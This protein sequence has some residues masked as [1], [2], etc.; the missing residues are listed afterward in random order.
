MGAAACSCEL[1]SGG[2]QPVEEIIDAS[3]AV[4][5]MQTEPKNLIIELK[6]RSCT[7][8]FLN[9]PEASGGESRDRAFTEPWNDSSKSKASVLPT[10]LFRTAQLTFS[11]IRKLRQA[12]GPKTCSEEDEAHPDFSGDWL[13][14]HVEGDVEALLKEVGAS[15]VQR[16]AAAAMGFGVGRQFVHVDQ[17]PDTIHIDTS[18][19]QADGNEPMAWPKPTN[20]V[21]NTGGVEQDILDPEGNTIRTVVNWDGQ[22]LAMV[23]E[24]VGCS[25][26]PLPSTR[27]YLQ[28][29]GSELVFEQTSATSGVAVKRVYRRCGSGVSSGSRS[30]KSGKSSKSK[31][32]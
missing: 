29:D 10:S 17:Y 23:S 14:H 11:F 20:N 31:G 25:G 21:Y 22:T 32:K 19:R 30:T 26:K 5:K 12:N 16:K 2:R 18:Y 15:W 27:R 13:L 3:S 1:S 7:D 9:L 28:E 8:A 6:E 24:R 4:Q